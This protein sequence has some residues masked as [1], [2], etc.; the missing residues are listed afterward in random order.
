MRPHQRPA[1]ADQ[2]PVDP[3]RIELL[4][5]QFEGMLGVVEA[6][7]GRVIGD[8]RQSRRDRGCLYSLRCRLRFEMLQPAIET[9]GAATALR[10]NTSRRISKQQA[11]DTREFQPGWAESVVVIRHGLLPSTLGEQLFLHESG[12]LARKCTPPAQR[13]HATKFVSDQKRQRRVNAAARNDRPLKLTFEIIAFFPIV[14]SRNRRPVANKCNGLRLDSVT[15]GPVPAV[16][17]PPGR[18]AHRPLP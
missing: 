10:G 14:Q 3:A 12:S 4:E 2:R 16:P 7:H 15:L 5:A 11:R 6:D 1:P 9:S 8:A 17:N 13:A 18:R